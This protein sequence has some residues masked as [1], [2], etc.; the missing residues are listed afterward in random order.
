MITIPRIRRELT[1]D[2]VGRHIYLFG[3]GS[4][5]EILE[6]LAETGERQGT[7]VLAAADGTKLSVAVVFRP[8]LAQSA[9]PLFSTIATLALGEAIGGLD[10]SASPVWPDQVAIGGEAVGRG[11][12]V[13]PRAFDRTSYVI[14]GA[15]IDVQALDARLVEVDQLIKLDETILAAA[16]LEEY[17]LIVGDLGQ[18]SEFGAADQRLA[19]LQLVIVDRELEVAV[20]DESDEALRILTAQVERFVEADILEVAAREDSEEAD[21]IANVEAAGRNDLAAERQRIV[22]LDRAEVQ[23]AVGELHAIL[24]RFTQFAALLQGLADVFNVDFLVIFHSFIPC[25]P[26]EED[27]ASTRSIGAARADR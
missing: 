20:G 13:T 19:P 24:E 8:R 15:E 26:G 10:P 12:I 5:P 7:V 1:S 4:A 3:A 17:R 14:L 25:G 27:P 2:L 6:R 11:L 22:D 16:N 23:I 18:R 21:I 9:V